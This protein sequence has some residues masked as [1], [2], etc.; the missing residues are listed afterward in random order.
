M[1][2]VIVLQP[3]LQNS[4]STVITALPSIII[5]RHGPVMEG[6]WMEDG[7]VHFDFE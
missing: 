7:I 5:G 4:F 2:V 3:I 6:G 1:R